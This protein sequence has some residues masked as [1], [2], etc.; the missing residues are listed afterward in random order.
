MISHGDPE[1]LTTTLP[2]RRSRLR[3]AGFGARQAA[4]L[5]AD[6]AYDVRALLA[7]VDRGCPPEVAARILAPLEPRPR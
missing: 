1:P 6:P 3:R 2:W 4:E 5:A 7:L